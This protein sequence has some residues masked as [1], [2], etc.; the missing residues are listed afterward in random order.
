MLNVLEKLVDDYKI[1]NELH[2]ISQ[3]ALLQKVYM[4]KM[5]IINKK[6]LD[7]L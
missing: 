5:I 4:D 2:R 6:M 3:S 1:E 7:L